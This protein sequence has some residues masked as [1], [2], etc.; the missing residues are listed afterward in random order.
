MGLRTDEH[1]P[2]YARINRKTDY[3]ISI[4]FNILREGFT[5]ICWTVSVLRFR[6]EQFHKL[7]ILD[8]YFDKLRYIIT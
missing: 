3:R 7:I 6:K 4:K 5:K 2:L 1:F 8:H